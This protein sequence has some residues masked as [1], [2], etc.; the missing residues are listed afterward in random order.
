MTHED[1][2]TVGVNEVMAAFRQALIA[3]VEPAERVG[4]Q[5]RPESTH[6]DWEALADALFVI[7]VEHSI[8][9]T[10]SS[11]EAYP[12]ARYDFDQ[13]DY[14]R[15][16]WIEVDTGKPSESD[17]FVR[18]SSGESPF[19]TAELIRV[20]VADGKALKDR[21]PMTSQARFRLRLRFPNQPDELIS[22]LELFE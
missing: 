22:V 3:L 14:A 6:D 13:L 18:F 10:P 1:V 11:S 5:W 4:L 2:L 19:D 7:L 16:S 17:I 12:I 15:N 9:Q 8:R 21:V 20:A